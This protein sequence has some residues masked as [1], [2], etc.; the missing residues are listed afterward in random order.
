MF[1]AYV[2]SK[3][4]G[5]NTEYTVKLAD[6]INAKSYSVGDKT[7]ISE[8]GINANSQKVVNV[9][10]GTVAK[11]SKD[12]INGGQLYDVKQEI[13]TDLDGKANVTLNNITNEGK[14]VITDLADSVD[15]TA[16]VTNTDGNLTVSS[17]KEGNLFI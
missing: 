4:D 1:D 12:A 2:D 6:D 15:D 13:N 8:T 16:E 9:A 14:K 10:D 11:D 3:V 7:Y 5:N 17:K